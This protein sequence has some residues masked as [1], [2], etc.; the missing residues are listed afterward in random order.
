MHDLAVQY[1]ALSDAAEQNEL[2]FSLLSGA[3]H[4]FATQGGNAAIALVLGKCVSILMRGGL[5]YP[6]YMSLAKIYGTKVEVVYEIEHFKV[7][8]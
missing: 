1:A 5:D 2:Q 6:D 4:I 3:E 7:M 8:K